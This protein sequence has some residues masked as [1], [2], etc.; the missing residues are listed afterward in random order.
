MK[1]V[2]EDIKPTGDAGMF[3]AIIKADGHSA[4][5]EVL[6]KDLTEC[7]LCAAKIVKGVK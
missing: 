2:I 4:A 1:C 7:V 3:K 6:G 5:I